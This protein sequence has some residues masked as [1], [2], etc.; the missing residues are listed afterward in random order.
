MNP[1]RAFVA[2]ELPLETRNLLKDIILELS[3]Y[4]GKSVR[5]VTP[6]N[7]HLTLRFLGNTSPAILSNLAQMIQKDMSRFTSF[8]ININKLGA[9]PNLRRPRVFWVGIEAPEALSKIQHTIEA[10]STTLG[11]PSEDKLFSPHLTLGR[12]NDNAS[13]QE[14]SRLAEKISTMKIGPYAP[15]SVQ[16][17]TIFKSDLQPGGPIYTPLYHAALLHPQISQ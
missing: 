7:I 2:I 8:E 12:V 10:S 17:I 14:L 6:Q 4:S 5:W 11:F 13:P 16:S 9:F 15:L 1:I 3:T